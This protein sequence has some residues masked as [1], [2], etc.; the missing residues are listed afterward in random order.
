MKI[1][2][3]HDITSTQ[4]YSLCMVLCSLNRPRLAKEALCTKDIAVIWKLVDYCNK[5]IKKEAA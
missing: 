1:Q 2:F 3:G 5:R 4:R